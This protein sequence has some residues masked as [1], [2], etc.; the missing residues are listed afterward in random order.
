MGLTIR[1]ARRERVLAGHPS[2]LAL[3]PEPPLDHP[4]PRSKGSPL[5]AVGGDLGDGFPD[6]GE[7]DGLPKELRFLLEFPNL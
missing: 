5:P 3:V 6:L 7:L 1:L 2:V 4:P